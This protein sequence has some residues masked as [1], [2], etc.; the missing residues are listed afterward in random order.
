VKIHTLVPNKGARKVAH[1]IGRGDASG[2]GTTAGKGHKGQ[3]ARSGGKVSGWFEGGQMPLYRRIPKWGFVAR[4]R[5]L[6]LNLY[7]IIDLDILESFEDGSVIDAEVL[8]AVGFAR[9]SKRKA[10][11]K[12]LGS[13]KLTKKLTVR[14]HAI[15]GSAKAAIE[16]L[17]GTVEVITKN[18]VEA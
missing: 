14:V 9:K 4:K 12:V 10:G 18:A 15:T 5:I 2:S 13:G 11:V 17:G 7:N 16:K 8:Q 6:G 3:K 1:R